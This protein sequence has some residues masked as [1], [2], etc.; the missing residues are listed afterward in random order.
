MKKESE[1]KPRNER[2]LVTTR[3]E[4]SSIKIGFDP[5]TGQILFDQPVINSHSEVAYDR[6]KGEKIISKIPLSP[7]KLRIDPNAAVE[8]SFDI[9]FAVD[10]NTKPIHGERV[11]VTGVMQCHRIF[12]IDQSGIAEQVWHYFSPIAFAFAGARDPAERAGWALAIELIH[13][14][15]AY[16]TYQQIAIIVDAYLG[17]LSSYN[18][19]Q[20]PIVPGVFLP[21]GFSL[22]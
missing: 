13:N 1:R 20:Q 7:D 16:S 10:T 8:S 6:A 14:S 5:A 19:R 3:D 11:S 15:A 12:V 18:T 9:V 4:V 17:D 21:E 22:L 2:I